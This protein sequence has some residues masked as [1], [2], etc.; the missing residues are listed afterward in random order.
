[1]RPVYAF[2]VLFVLGFS[3]LLSAEDVAVSPA[4]EDGIAWYNAADWPT[5]GKG[6][7]ETAR[8]FDRIPDAFAEKIPQ[9]QW[10]LIHGEKNLR[11]E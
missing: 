7:T 2:F 1:M 4:I 3:T 9:G 11:D 5:E 6:W 8:P 10:L